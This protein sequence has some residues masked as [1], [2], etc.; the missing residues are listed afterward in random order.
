MLI[1]ELIPFL[2][3]ILIPLPG[4]IAIPTSILIPEAILIAKSASEL[5]LELALE[6]VPKC[7]PESVPELESVPKLVPELEL[8]PVLELVP[9]SESVSLSK[10]APGIGIGSEIRIGFETESISAIKKW[11]LGPLILRIDAAVVKNPNLL[12]N[13]PLLPD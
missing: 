6:L 11:H 9:E 3:S 1:P 10:S 8:V 13:D 12:I 7:T 2:K 5:S 4:P